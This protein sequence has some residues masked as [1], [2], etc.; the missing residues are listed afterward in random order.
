MCSDDQKEW[1][2]D[3]INKID[4]GGGSIT[5]ALQRSTA[6]MNSAIEDLTKSINKSSESSNRLSWVVAISTA[7]LA[8][9]GVADLCARIFNIGAKFP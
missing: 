7:V 2:S 4:D 1:R 8:A 9:I 5:F 3:K 6:I